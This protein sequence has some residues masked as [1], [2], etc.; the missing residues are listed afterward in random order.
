MLMPDSL[1]THCLADVTMC[2]HGERFRRA[3]DSKL[4]QHLSTETLRYIGVLYGMR[5]RAGYRKDVRDLPARFVNFIPS[6]CL[7]IKSN[8]C[9]ISRRAAKNKLAKY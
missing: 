7:P 4:G 6:P 5:G 2:C 3:S 8:T 9:P 1:S